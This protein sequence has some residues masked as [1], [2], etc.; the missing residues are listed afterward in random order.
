MSVQKLIWQLSFIFLSAN[1]V[2]LTNGQQMSQYS[3][4]MHNRLNVNPAFCG[5]DKLPA[6]ETSYRNQWLGVKGSPTAYMING[7]VP[8]PRFDNS[9]G[10]AATRQHFGL[11]NQTSVTV[12][13]AHHFKVHHGKISMGIK[14]G[15]YNQMVNWNQSITIQPNDPSLGVGIISSSSPDFGA[16]GL[17]IA[18]NYYVGL[19]IPSFYRHTLE[20]NNVKQNMETNPLNW[21]YYFNTGFTKSLNQRF[22]LNCDVVITTARG[23][24]LYTGM[25]TSIKWY[26]HF[27]AGM[28]LHNLNMVIIH[29]GFFVLPLVKLNYS[30]DLN[31]SKLSNVTS[32]THEISLVYFPAN[33]LLKI[34]SPIY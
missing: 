4:I 30:Y 15:W 9:I 24:P 33:K 32:N 8:V 19:S 6:F 28:G 3:L 13:Y 34:E 2:L 25:L 7:Q 1:I 10:F 20:G 5:V 27:S 23:I 16:G 22:S 11:V 12:C 29:A 14:G 31:L 26:D 21:Q 17:F 18:S